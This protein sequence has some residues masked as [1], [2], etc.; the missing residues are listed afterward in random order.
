MMRSLACAVVLVGLLAGAVDA[1]EEPSGEVPPGLFPPGLLR[2]PREPTKPHPA[3]ARLRKYGGVIHTNVGDITIRLHP[4]V[5][6]NAVRNF[7]KLA[8]RGFYDGARIYCI[9]KGRMFLAGDPTGSGKG[10][11][12]TT[13]RF[14]PSLV[15]H[16]AGSL[17]MD[18]R[19]D[20]PDPETAGKERRKVNSG[21][22]FMVSVAD[23]RHLDG[24]YTI[25]ATITQGLSVAQ[26]IAA[27]RTRPNDG[28]PVPIEDIVIEQIDITRSGRAAAET[29]P[30]SPSKNAPKH[31][32]GG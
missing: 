1:G 18:R 9:F 32:S 3:I 4:E 30:K 17:A 7:I 28:A 11:N 31:P 21:S 24:D 19:P 5:A 27:A 15:P 6:P 25:F 2:P 16:L 14:E 8:Q 22:R 10:D 26:R 23:Q 29:S 13:L 20:E 12:G